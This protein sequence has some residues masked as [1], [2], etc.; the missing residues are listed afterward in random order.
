MKIFNAMQI[1][2]DNNSRNLRLSP[3]ANISDIEIKGT[4]GYITIGVPAEVA[5][6]LL[7]NRS[8]FKGG[9]ILCDA[10]ELDNLTKQ[11]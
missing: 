3:L 4:N 7:N 8:K 11:P 2:A 10:Q 1:M 5:F 9:L 6:E